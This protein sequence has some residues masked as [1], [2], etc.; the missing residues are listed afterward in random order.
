MKQRKNKAVLPIAAI[1]TV[2]FLSPILLNLIIMGV[3]D[4]VARGI[5]NDLR[6]LRLPENTEMVS[7]YSVAGKVVG[8]GNGM[9][10]F[11]AI[12]IESELTLEELSDYYSE[13]NLRYRV[14]KQDEKAIKVLDHG[15]HAFK[16]KESTLVNH[17]I[18]YTL[19][20]AKNTFLREFD[21]R[22]H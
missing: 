22:G 21:I 9:Q 6:N 18:V 7:S 16:V 3:N 5:R 8:N 11:G 15:S 19:D 1:V 12:L 2:L 14:Q 13:V 4:T 20:D 17:Y 10:Y